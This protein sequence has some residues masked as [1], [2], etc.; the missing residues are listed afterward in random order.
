MRLIHTARVNW[1]TRLLLPNMSGVCLWRY[2]TFSRR[3]HARP[4]ARSSWYVSRQSVTVDL[5]V[6]SRDITVRR[7]RLSRR[8][9]WL[10][11]KYIVSRI[12]VH[13]TLIV[14]ICCNVGTF[15]FWWSIDFDGSS[16]Y[17]THS[18]GY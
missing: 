13:N 16:K 17:V 6:T 8:P 9:A 4:L 15:D 3:R 1:C 2:R 18:T 10:R 12:C 7:L 11:K 5:Q 14:S